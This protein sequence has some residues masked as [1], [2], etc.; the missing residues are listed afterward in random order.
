LWGT[1]PP[2]VKPGPGPRVRTPKDAGIEGM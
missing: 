2:E 1:V